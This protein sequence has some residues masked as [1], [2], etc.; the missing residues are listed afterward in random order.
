MAGCSGTTENPIM[1]AAK[2][3]E[4]SIDGFQQER[5]GDVGITDKSVCADLVRVFDNK[6]D[7]NGKV[8]ILSSLGFSGNEI[9]QFK[10]H[11]G[12]DG[13]QG[14]RNQAKWFAGKIDT[15]RNFVGRLL[16][17]AN[18][19]DKLRII[20]KLSSSGAEGESAL[21]AL[22]SNLKDKDPEIRAAAIKAIGN[23]DSALH[24]TYYLEELIQSL[25]DPFPQVREAA[26]RALGQ[27]LKDK[28]GEKFE[29]AIFALIGAVADSEFDVSYVASEALKQ[30]VLDKPGHVNTLGY[31]GHQNNR[32]LSRVVELLG[33]CKSAAKEPAKEILKATFEDVDNSESV[34]SAALK[35]FEQITEGLDNKIDDMFYEAIQYPVGERD[36]SLLRSNVSVLISHYEKG[37]SAI[38]PRIISDLCLLLSLSHS[39]ESTLPLQEK[40]AEFLGKK[41]PHTRAVEETLQE[42][43]NRPPIGDDA[44]LR[45][46][47]E[48]AL[49]LIKRRP[50]QK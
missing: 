26:A 3:N 39:F 11:M 45:K 49:T 37:D 24:A 21:V 46:I 43:V 6:L 34:K 13:N 19:A 7:L 33:F 22:A 27:L 10:A 5:C 2:I 12:S 29:E 18:D 20:E 32:Y 42:L 35:A 50:L 44:G 47:S 40:V 36:L 9:A 23:I 25:K 41:G 14:L 4:T 28:R 17:S 15:R 31:I 16:F 1:Q 8:T 48:N 38:P 30:I